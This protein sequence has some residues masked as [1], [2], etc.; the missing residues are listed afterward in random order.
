MPTASVTPFPSKLFFYLN[1]NQRF[2]QII[3][4]VSH[5]N[6][7]RTNQNNAVNQK[8]RLSFY[9]TKSASHRHQLF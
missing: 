2:K 4:F 8:N 6:I 7:A 5:K 1:A 9:N 3:E